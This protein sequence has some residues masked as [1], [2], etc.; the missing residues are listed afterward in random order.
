MKPLSQILAKSENKKF[1]K[2]S[3]TLVQHTSNA[4]EVWKELY[5]RYNLTLGLEEDFWI[6]SLIA[7]LFHDF[8]KAT[9]NFQELTLSDP[10]KQLFGLP[11]EE[12]YL[13]DNRIR[14]E[15]ISGLYLLAADGNFYVK[16]PESLLAVFTHHKAFKPSLFDDQQEKVVFVEKQAMITF[17]DF[18]KTKV[19]Q[20]FGE[21]YCQNLPPLSNLNAINKIEKALESKNMKSLYF[22]FEKGVNQTIIGNIKKS[23]IPQQHRQKYIFHKAILNISDWVASGGSTTLAKGLFFSD[24]YVENKVK[25]RAKEHFKGFRKFQKECIQP[26][27]IIAIAPTGSGK[28]EAA[29]LWA[30]QKGENERIIYALPTRVTANAIWQRLTD[31]FPPENGEDHTAVVHASAHFLRKELED[32][33][34]QFRYMRDRCFFRNI[35][36]CTVDQLL[37]M[38]FNVA[39]WEIRIFHL[40]RA[41]IVIDEV[42]L[43]A[44]YTLGLICA[45]IKFMREHFETRFFIMSA[46]MPQKL[47][48]LLKQYLGD[49]NE[50]TDTELLKEARNTFLVKDKSIDELLSEIHDRVKAKNKVLLVVNTVDEAIRLYDSPIFAKLKKVCYHSRFI[51]KHRKSKEDEILGF[52]GE[53]TEGVLLISTQVCEVS[54]DIDYDFLYSENAPI[55]AIIQRAGRVN[56]KRKKEETEVI[57]FKHQEVTE[58]HIYPSE[59]LK[60]TYELLKTKHGQRLTELELTNLVE[61]VYRNMIIEENDSFKEGFKKYDVLQEELEYLRDLGSQD[62]E[63]A[64]TRE[65]LDSISVIPDLYEIVL[66][67]ATIEEKTKH[68]VSIRSSF[69]NSFKCTK[70]SNKDHK[71]QYIEAVYSYE[72]GLQKIKSTPTSSN[73]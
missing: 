41:W 52:E 22:Q 25:E 7:I 21:E 57:I 5:N 44:P 45:T 23:S 11:A 12:K 64:F 30:S 59:I 33:Y 2:P 49:T 73:I 47:K 38:G 26:K 42:H 71:F 43:Y 9:R 61:N 55:D 13:T 16:N 58:K 31:Y 65:G 70:D 56:R 18:A 40:H 1:G 6:R 3:E 8:G 28:T 10:K 60:D 37:T 4:V 50:V 36:I 19:A 72:R 53:N 29:L 51:N 15:F 46:T 32:N 69:Y 66:K 54:L 14:H 39:N 67:N 63:K 68:E 62:L 20:I 35:S 27:N 17:L 34:D 48:D 24:T